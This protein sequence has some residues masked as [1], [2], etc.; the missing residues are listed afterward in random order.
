LGFCQEVFSSSRGTNCACCPA[1][2]SKAL[3]NAERTLEAIY[4][5]MNDLQRDEELQRLGVGREDI[6]ATFK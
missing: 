6:L 5:I 2:E 1:R 3:D 4:F